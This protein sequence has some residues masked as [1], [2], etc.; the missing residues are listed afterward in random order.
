MDDTISVELDVQRATISVG[1]RAAARCVEAAL[2]RPAIF[3]RGEPLMWDG[4][5]CV[6]RR[7]DLRP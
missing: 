4:G 1:V 3:G 5:E 6:E 7:A 2:P